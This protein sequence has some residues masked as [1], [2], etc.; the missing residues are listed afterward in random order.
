MNILVTGGNRGLGRE[1]VRQMALQGHTVILTARDA[2][3][4][5]KT[6]EALQE[7]TSNSNIIFI[8]MDTSSTE[9]IHNSFKNVSWKVK[10][11]DVLINNAGVSI[12]SD[13]T[14]Q[15]SMDNMQATFQTNFY[16]PFQVSQ[17]FMPLLKQAP[18]ARIINVSSG[19]GSL[20]NIT[21]GYAAYR[22]SKTALN[23]LTAVMAADVEKYNIKVF[24]VC[25][26]WVHTDMG[27]KEA[28]R[29]PEE[30]GRSIL[31]LVD[32]PNAVS[33]KFYRDGEII[34]Y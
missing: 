3:K 14:T 10:H 12:N 7:E 29:T 34:A 13:D 11:L 24:A 32:A 16:G 23:S 22:I 33:G 17:V 31:W 8:Q 26:G 25:P 20:T 2:E 5:K 19:M 6:V 18:A 21:G 1:V 4:G 30:G 27:G 28:P 9:S 15:V